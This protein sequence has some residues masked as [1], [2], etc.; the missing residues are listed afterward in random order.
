MLQQP[1][2]NICFCCTIYLHYLMP[3]MFS[4]SL[5]ALNVNLYNTPV[6]FGTRNLSICE[7]LSLTLPEHF[8]HLLCFLFLYVTN[9]I[10]DAHILQKL[11]NTQSVPLWS[12]LTMNIHC[13]IMLPQSIISKFSHQA[14][15]IWAD[16]IFLCCCISISIRF[17]TLRL[18]IAYATH[19]YI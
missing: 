15:D 16:S 12:D 14:E 9:W 1:V 7:Y 13:W 17:V 19:C 2:T 10:C 11:P 4:I 8:K 18:L 3:C 5:I 6:F